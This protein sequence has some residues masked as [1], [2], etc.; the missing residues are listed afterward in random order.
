[1]KRSNLWIGVF[2][3]ICC[4]FPVPGRAADLVIQSGGSAT[5]LALLGQAP[6]HVTAAQVTDARLVEAPGSMLLLALWNEQAPGGPPV[7]HYAFSFDGQTFAVA[8][9][10][11]YE[12]KQAPTPFDPLVGI[13]DVPPVLYFG[14]T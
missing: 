11:S 1:M 14:P 8:R 13:P 9:A 3:L 4:L 7:P 6:F 5:E 10:T 12:I 2:V